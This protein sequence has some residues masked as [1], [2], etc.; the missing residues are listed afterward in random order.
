[1]TSYT[2]GLI[3]LVLLKMKVSTDSYPGYSLSNGKNK[4][5]DPGCEK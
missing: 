4:K 5:N 2:L 3:H 1:M